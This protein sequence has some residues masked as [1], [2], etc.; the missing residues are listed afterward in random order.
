MTSSAHIKTD[1]DCLQLE[2]TNLN[3]YSRHSFTGSTNLVGLSPHS[4][5]PKKQPSINFGT[6]VS[7]RAGAAITGFYHRTE[8]SLRH[9]LPQGTPTPF[10][11]M[12]VTVETISLF[13]Q[14]IA[15]AIWLTANIMATHL[16]IHL[17]Q[18]KA[19]AL[20]RFHSVQFNCLV[21]FDSL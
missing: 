20:I 14:S 8:A 17:I 10:I 3:T 15:L 21:L 18:G 16:L 2:E 5:M 9:F 6:A 7:L 4:T 12:P 11:P 19:L 13:V 1:H